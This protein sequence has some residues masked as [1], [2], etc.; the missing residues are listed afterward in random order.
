MQVYWTTQKR[1]LS[2]NVGEIS[3]YCQFFINMFINCCYHIHIRQLVFVN[4]SLQTFANSSQFVWKTSWQKY[5]FKRLT[6]YKL[7][8][9]SC[10]CSYFVLY[11][12]LKTLYHPLTFSRRPRP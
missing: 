4:T 7:L 2:E 10:S 11:K 5:L 6:L 8:I 3:V 9:S 12:M 1:L